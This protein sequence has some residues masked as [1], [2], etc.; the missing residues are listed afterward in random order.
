MA[1]DGE[2]VAADGSLVVVRAASLCVHGDT[3][4]AAAL[5]LRVRDALAAAG[6]TVEAF[7]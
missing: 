5:A 3:P 6:V 7:A 1:R 4:G 2:V